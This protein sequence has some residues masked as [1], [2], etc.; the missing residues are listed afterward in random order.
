MPTFKH[1]YSSALDYELGTD[2]STRLF[3]DGRRKQS[4]NEGLEQFAELTECFV[5]ESTLVSS[6]GVREYSLNSTLNIPGNDYVRPARQRPEFQLTSSH[7]GSSAQITYVSGDAFERRE[8]DWLNQY[9]PG[10]RESTGGTPRFWYE[11]MDGGVRFFGLHPP[12]EIGSSETAKVRFPYVAKPP[13]LTSD[14]DVPYSVAST[15]IGG[16][17]GIRT[18]LDV[19]HQ[20]AVHYAAHKLEKLR[21]NTEAS[22]MQLQT[23]LGWVEK[24]LAA[25]TP[26]GGQTLKAARS[27]FA[28]ARRKRSAGL[29]LPA[30]T[31]WGY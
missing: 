1:L 11:R 8:I 23:F 14:T 7:G 20:A 10:W 3:T 28:D 26:K 31:G 9:E 15:A 30:K 24:Y 29:D 6:H 21:V 13:V 25:R 5:R 2:D 22:Q 19:Y 4:V 27:Y 18:D 12:P 16:S 17:T